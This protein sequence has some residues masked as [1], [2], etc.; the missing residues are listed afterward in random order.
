[1]PAADPHHG[2]QKAQSE[3]VEAKQRIVYRL[4]HVVNVGPV[5]DRCT[6]NMHANTCSCIRT[7]KKLSKNLRNHHVI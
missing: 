3:D 6:T 5:S 1:M 4:Q 2:C 7:E